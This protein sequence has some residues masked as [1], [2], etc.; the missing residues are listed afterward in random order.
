MLFGDGCHLNN[1][2]SS[3]LS[4]RRHIFAT[5]EWPPRNRRSVR[6]A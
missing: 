6:L 2:T 1:A 5:R 4:F 3:L